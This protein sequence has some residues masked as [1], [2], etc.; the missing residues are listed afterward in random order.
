MLKRVM[1]VTAAIGML[2]APAMS[3]AAAE[4]R[5][6]EAFS[7]WRAQG[8]IFKTGENNGT[9]VGALRGRFFVITPEGP[10]EAGT[11]VCPGTLEIDLADAS[12]SGQGPCVIVGE[13]DARAFATWTC[14]GYHLVGCRGDFTL[15]GGAGKFAGVTGGGPFVIRSSIHRLAATSSHA[16]TTINEASIGIAHW[17]ELRYILP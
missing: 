1:L 10:L 5:T 9:F 8:Q 15:T 16:V 11:I 2:Q 17:K 4:E 14:S 12:Q 7:V 6:I 3:P 13:G